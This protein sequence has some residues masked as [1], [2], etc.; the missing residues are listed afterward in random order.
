MKKFNVASILAIIGMVLCA[1]YAVLCFT[2][3]TQ[4]STFS[5]PPYTYMCGY[6]IVFSFL[7]WF[8][9]EIYKHE[10]SK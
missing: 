2:N 3:Q 1:V 4:F 7:T 10:Q 9:Y 5:N 6:G 8:M